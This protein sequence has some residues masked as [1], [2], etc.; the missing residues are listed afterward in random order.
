MGFQLAKIFSATRQFI[1]TLILKVLR[2]TLKPEGRRKGNS[3]QGRILAVA[4]MICLRCV[5]G[6]ATL[7]P[8]P[9]ISE[10]MV[11][12]KAPVA[13]SILSDVQVVDKSDSLVII[14]IGSD[15]MVYTVFITIR[16]LELVLDMPDAAAQTVPPILNVDNQLQ[17]RLEKTSLS[18]ASEQPQI[19]PI[20][21]SKAEILRPGTRTD[22]EFNVSRS[23]AKASMS[24]SSVV[25]K[26]PSVSASK[27]L[28]LDSVTMSQ[29]LRFY[30]LAD[31]SLTNFKV[32]HL[33]DP[34]RVVVDLMDIQ[35]I[36]TPDVWRLNGP[37][38]SE[39]RIGLKENK[40]RL[41]FRLVP[42]AGLPYKVS[43]ENNTMQISFT[44]GP[45]F[46][47]R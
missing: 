18:S 30:I 10:K 38:V 25:K 35:S 42:E 31:G 34:P 1:P 16:P 36:E 46:A 3:N 24:S 37:L 22:Q 27:I 14:L 43:P 19:E 41:V 28:D 23:A 20:V 47:S 21:E 45:G 8:S 9:P 4:F 29:E 11:K 2:S 26:E 6:C 17:V 5:T 40:V 33:T 44:Q 12:E 39:I 15:N 13:P 32:F 7:S